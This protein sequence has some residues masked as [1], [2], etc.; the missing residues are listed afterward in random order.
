MITTGKISAGSARQVSWPIRCQLQVMRCACHSPRG[1]VRYPTVASDSA[2]SRPGR[3]PPTNS[4]VTDTLVAA[5]AR[6][7]G[8]LGGMMMPMELLAAVT[9]AE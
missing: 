3:Y 1:R 8:T 5:P 7:M 9:A 2:I 6:I 4:F